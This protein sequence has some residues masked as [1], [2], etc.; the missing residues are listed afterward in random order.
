MQ[1][2]LNYRGDQRRGGWD[3]GAPRWGCDRRGRLNTERFDQHGDHPRGLM[4]GRMCV[5]SMPDRQRR[6]V[7]ITG[8]EPPIEAVASHLHRELGVVPLCARGDPPGGVVVLG[9]ML[10]WGI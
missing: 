9:P 10:P 5:I 7:L 6:G 1:C 3:I 8:G 2:V 4:Q